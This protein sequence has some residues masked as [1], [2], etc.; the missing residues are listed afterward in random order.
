MTDDTTLIVI[1]LVLACAVIGLAVLIILNWRRDD[2]PSRPTKP[3]MSDD[4]WDGK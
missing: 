3:Y 4:E 1:V 2:L